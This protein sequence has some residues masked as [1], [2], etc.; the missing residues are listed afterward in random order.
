MTQC[1]K[2]F[3]VGLEMHEISLGLL[4]DGFK[5]AFRCSFKNYRIFEG[6][7]MHSTQCLKL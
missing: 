7:E 4:I 5:E 3:F 6:A 2:I 1:L